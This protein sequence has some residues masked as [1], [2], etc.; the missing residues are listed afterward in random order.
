M[1]CIP[2]CQAF[3]GNNMPWH[4]DINLHLAAA[5]TSCDIYNYHLI[6][7]YIDHA[8]EYTF[9]IVSSKVQEP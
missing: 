3:N 4:D 9:G 2:I 6:T 5:G 1:T 7:S 8:T